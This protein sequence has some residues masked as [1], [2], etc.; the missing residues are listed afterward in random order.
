M[1]T[2]K[3]NKIEFSPEVNRAALIVKPKKPFFDWLIYT[4]NEYDKPEERIDP[5]TV[6]RE[7]MDS[8]NVYLMPVYDENKQYDEI[9]KKHYSKIF[10]SELND[11]YI[12]P[13]MWPKD[14]SWKEFLKWFEYEVQTVVYD[15]APEFD[16][17]YDD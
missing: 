10:N 11:W 1:N 14:R 3:Y 16:I 7:G 8:K 12:D 9:L 4:S 13:D 5:K 15:L 2:E 6:D 17:E